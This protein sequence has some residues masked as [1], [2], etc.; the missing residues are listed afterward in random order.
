MT[1]NLLAKAL[2]NHVGKALATMRLETADGKEKE[3]P[4]GS[5]QFVSYFLWPRRK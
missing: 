5:W 3:I 2:R 1:E 4:E